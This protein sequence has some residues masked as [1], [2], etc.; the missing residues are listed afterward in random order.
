MRVKA[1]KSL[2]FF[3]CQNI[4]GTVVVPILMLSGKEVSLFNIPKHNEIQRMLCKLA[5]RD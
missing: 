2:L 1:K 4:I 5:L 3:D